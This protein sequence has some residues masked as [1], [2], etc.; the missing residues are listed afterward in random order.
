MGLLGLMFA[1]THG[2]TGAGDVEMMTVMEALGRGLAAEPYL[3]EILLA[4]RLL[5]E[6][7]TPQQ[8]QTWLPAIIAGHA[9][10]ALA[11]AEHATRFDLTRCRTR[12]SAGRL[13]GAKTCVSGGAD[14]YVVTASDAGALCLCLV[15]ADAPG[16]TRRDYRLVDGS[17]AGELQFSA[18]PAEPLPGGLEVL[19]RVTQSARIGASAEMMGLMSLLFDS[20][21]DYVRQ[22]RQFGAPIGSFQAIQHRLA[23]VYMSLELSRAH[24][25]RCVLA[26]AAVRE[27]AVA[28]AKSYIS[29]AAIRLGE[30]CIQFHGGM[31]VSDELAIG[32]AHKRILVLAS[33]LGDADC[34]LVR[35]NREAVVSC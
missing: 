17:V 31:G 7:G 13:T 14:A 20:T 8:Q 5:E 16:L 3:N 6:A 18:A 23:D 15:Q 22:R 30:E 9:H 19:L 1:E 21:L 26:P 32:H 35:Y 12:F 2:G 28:A 34:E 29:T 25:Y 11:H 33:F 10:V 27:S 4:G 24:L